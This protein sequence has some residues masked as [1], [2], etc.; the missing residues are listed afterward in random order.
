MLRSVEKTLINK[1]SPL[2][3][4]NENIVQSNK[5][6][7]IFFIFV[8][9]LSFYLSICLEASRTPINNKNGFI[10]FPLS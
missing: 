7:L 6:Y 5:S 2:V 3:I 9:T 10:S 1:D 8:N 4:Q